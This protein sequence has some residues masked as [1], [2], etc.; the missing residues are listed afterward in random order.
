[1]QKEALK[2]R[3]LSDCPEA[4][5]ELGKLLRQTWPDWYA[6]HGPGNPDQDLARY[7][8]HEPLPLG[9]VAFSN[10]TVCGFAGLK[11]DAISGYEHLQPWAGA[12]L[13]QENLRKKGIGS[14]PLRALQKE[15]RDR[16]FEKKYAGTSQA[17]NLL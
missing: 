13:V 16:G 17:G 9:L 15:A 6:P 5:P 3:P 4:L 11:T 2:F 8:N 1:M 12:A 10:D 14:E 7:A